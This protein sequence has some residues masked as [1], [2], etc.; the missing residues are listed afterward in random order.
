[1]PNLTPEASVRIISQLQSTDAEVASGALREL[2]PEGNAALIVRRGGD[3]TA[4]VARSIDPSF[5]MTCL[6]FVQNVGNAAG[7]SLQWVPTKQQQARPGI[8][9]PGGRPFA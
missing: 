4:A 7:L 3:A 6:A 9:L 2:F 8:L 1:M 5:W